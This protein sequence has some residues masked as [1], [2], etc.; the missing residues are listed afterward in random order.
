MGPFKD[1]PLDT[2][3]KPAPNQP[4]FLTIFHEATGG[5]RDRVLDLGSARTSLTLL[6]FLM[7]QL[8]SLLEDAKPVLPD[9]REKLTA[10]IHYTKNTTELVTNARM[11]FSPWA[12]NQDTKKLIQLAKQIDSQLQFVRSLS[13]VLKCRLELQASDRRVSFLILQLQDIIMDL[14]KSFRLT[15]AGN[16]VTQQLHGFSLFVLGTLCIK[17]VCLNALN[18]S[19][20]DFI[21]DGC[22]SKRDPAVAL[23][24]KGVATK[25][26]SLGFGLIFHKGN[27]VFTT[28]LREADTVSALVHAE[29]HL[30]ALRHLVNVTLNGDELSFKT[31]GLIFGQHMASLDVHAKTDSRILAGLIY[32]VT[33]KLNHSSQLSI[34]LVDRIG[35][36]IQSIAE[37]S[38]KKLQDTV[39]ALQ[40]GTKRREKAQ[41][42][43]QEKKQALVR[44]RDKFYRKE[45]AAKNNYLNYAVAKEDFNASLHI[46]VGQSSGTCIFRRCGY[47]TTPMCVPKLCQKNVTSS[48]YV[49]NCQTKTETVTEQQL[50]KVTIE[51]SYMEPTFIT[52]HSSSCKSHFEQFVDST[53]LASKK[54]FKIWLKW[55]GVELAMHGVQRYARGLTRGCDSY[56]W[57]EDG[58]PKRV[59]YETEEVTVRSIEKE[60]KKFKCASPSKITH[61]VGFSRPEA[62]CENDTVDILDAECVAFN[63][64][65]AANNTRLRTSLQAVNTN[66][67]KKFQ[68]MMQYGERASLVQIELNKARVELEFAENQYELAR[69]RFDQQKYAEGSI[70]VTTVRDRERFGLKLGE[71]IRKHGGS[72]LVKVQNLGFAADVYTA[73][74]NILPFNISVLTLDGERKH[75]NARID[76]GQ[77]ESS[78][79]KAAKTIVRHLY[80]DS[81][82]K[83]K[84]RSTILPEQYDSDESMVESSQDPCLVSKDANLY[85]SEIVG[86]LSLAIRS[87]ETLASEMEDGRR[88]LEDPHAG[89][90]ITLH[91]PTPGTPL[92]Q[93]SETLRSAYADIIEVL[94]Q[95][96]MPSNAPSWEETLQDWR[97]FLEL[98]TRNKNFSDC[99]GTHD[100]INFFFDELWEMYEV[101]DDPEALEIRNNLESLQDLMGNFTT[102]N[103]SLIEAASL[104]S[105]IL[106]LLNKTND[107]NIL[108]GRKP[109]IR[110]SPQEII[111]LVGRTLKL[112][113][114]AFS[115]T[116]MQYL[117]RKNGEIIETKSGRSI[118]LH[119]INFTES[120]AYNCEAT[121]NRG[122]AV[123]N[124]T[125]VRV[126]SR[127]VMMAEPNDVTTKDTS[128][129]MAFFVCN[130]TGTP[131]PNFQWYFIPEGWD[132]ERGI[133]LSV[134]NEVL[135]KRNLSSS[136]SGQ[137]YCRASNIHGQVESKK[138]RLY[139][140][141]YSPATPTVSV[142]FNLTSESPANSSGAT[143][144]G[145]NIG[146][147][148][149]VIVFDSHLAN[150]TTKLVAH[151]LHLSNRDL[152]KHIHFISGPEAQLSF[153]IVTK[154]DL[155]TDDEEAVLNEF[156]NS[157]LRLVKRV[158]SLHEELKNETFSIPWK[159]NLKIRGKANTLEAQFSRPECPKG[160]EVDGN[161]FLC[162][163]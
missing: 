54:G 60:V 5:E 36:F 31:Q 57:V 13:I 132:P 30:F 119:N 46:R 47:Q 148:D 88:S 14:P 49:P 17:R 12:P 27:A 103:L 23:Y 89:D 137:Y 16:E 21:E 55:S 35:N 106:V 72:K 101:E 64:E 87:F 28:I 18:L 126:H 62:C 92:Q 8:E 141:D 116:R 4:I 56:T 76:F 29:V 125:I 102:M 156:A 10:W 136:D 130:A 96:Q 80:G 121:N 122:K 154:L 117:W 41:D 152:V 85:F 158:K 149:N 67:A 66:L 111:A 39:E 143:E 140:L 144:E 123:S 33:G 75:L 159:G 69:A 112:S 70:N 20:Q 83:R 127:P 91:I 24:V 63:E 115:K 113:C 78:V 52:R 129:E 157:R 118:T 104:E 44:A 162:G 109:E 65:C 145:S 15:L 161:G 81:G 153:V 32:H 37:K 9:I 151:Y 71:E 124:F 7:R 42:V 79:E 105:E 107:D 59:P 58:P 22:T 114:E 84:R 146:D 19:L 48:Y 90:N 133:P 50:D 99:S 135:V 68:R 51:K 150:K 61:H 94:R 98:F 160:Q 95:E 45:R 155:S 34:L 134:S 147:E 138:A 131:R 97:G 120:G 86:S 1:T 100:C 38:E 74:Q 26:V 11:D 40:A 43:F 93:F 6:R 2:L 139:V 3:V 163:E 128:K 108:C 142:K 77:L 82:A 110:S 73:E 53:V 25:S